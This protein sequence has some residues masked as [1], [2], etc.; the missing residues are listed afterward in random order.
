MACFGALAKCMSKARH[1]PV[2]A[3]R[4]GALGKRH[5]FSLCKALRTPGFLHLEY[6]RYETREF[7]KGKISY[8]RSL[9]PPYEFAEKQG[10]QSIQPYGATRA[11]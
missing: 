8:T 4:Q 2:A 10:I 5:S 11:N 6:M 7:L 3:V 1:C 9:Y